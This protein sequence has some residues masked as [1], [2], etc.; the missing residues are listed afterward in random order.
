MKL[1]YSTPIFYPN[2]LPHIGHISTWIY[3]DMMCRYKI[4]Q[5][6]KE[7]YLIT[8][9]D[10]HGT[11]VREASENKKIDTEDYI[12]EMKRIWEK[13]FYTCVGKGQVVY[14]FNTTLS[15]HHELNVIN[16]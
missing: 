4:K 7:V 15:K 14:L 9:L 12:Y 13:M 3:A 1:V 16:K 2:G 6:E 11:K 10:S 5:G 8:G